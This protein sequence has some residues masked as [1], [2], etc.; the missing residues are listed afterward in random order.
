MRAHANEYDGADCYVSFVASGRYA[1]AWKRLLAGD[2]V[3]YVRNLKVRGYF[4]AEEAPY[5]KGVVSLQREFL[6]RLR[7]EAPPP[8]VDLEWVRLVHL[9]P[10]LQFSV[11]DLLATPAGPDFAEAVA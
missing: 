9:V 11:A 8:A 7:Q 5:T 4:T 2:A 10:T 6:A 3:G 1:E